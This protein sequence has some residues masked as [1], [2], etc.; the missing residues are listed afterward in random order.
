MIYRVYEI[1]RQ[2]AALLVFYQRLNVRKIAEEVVQ[3]GGDDHPEIGTEEHTSHDRAS[4]G[5]IT[6]G[7]SYVR[8]DQGYQTGHEGKGGHQN[9]TETH[10]RTLDGRFEQRS[11][12]LPLLYAKLHNQHGIFP[13]QTYQHD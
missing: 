11:S 4:D 1:L 5:S 9:R 3:T 10:F 12:L 8:N 6:D 2:R 13:K 7:T